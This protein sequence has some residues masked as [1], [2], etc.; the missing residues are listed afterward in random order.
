V[1]PRE[2]HPDA[3]PEAEELLEIPPALPDSISVHRGR[4]ASGPYTLIEAQPRTRVGGQ[5]MWVVVLMWVAVWSLFQWGLGVTSIAISGVV[6]CIAYVVIARAGNRVRIHITRERLALR[7]VPLPWPGAHFDAADVTQLFVERRVHAVPERYDVASHR[8]LLTTESGPGHV[9]LIEDVDAVI[10]LYLERIIED[11]LGIEDRP[12]SG[13][14]A[15]E[16]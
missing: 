10:G 5:A 13:E 2:A 14:I 8:L 6:L 15:D 16:I 1:A 7:Y 9:T 3:A 12:M 4:S 11:A